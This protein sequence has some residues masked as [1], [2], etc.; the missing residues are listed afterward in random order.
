MGDDIAVEK[1]L[2]GARGVVGGVMPGLERR[3]KWSTEE[4]FRILAQSVAPGSS[5][6]LTRK[7]HGISSGHLYTW[8]KP[9][10]HGELTGF[11]PVSIIPE[12]VA[13]SVRVK[14]RL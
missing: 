13:L 8:R 9:F 11:V 14:P 10:R 5:P 1:V 6:A 12:P 2:R 7:M 3:R 4:K